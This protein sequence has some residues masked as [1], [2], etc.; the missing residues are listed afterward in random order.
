MNVLQNLLSHTVSPI[1]GQRRV[2]FAAVHTGV[3]SNST[4]KCLLRLGIHSENVID[5]VPFQTKYRSGRFYG[6]AFLLLNNIEN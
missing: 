6:A 5:D 2:E 1:R 3:H 4:K